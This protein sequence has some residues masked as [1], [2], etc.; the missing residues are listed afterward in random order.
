MHRATHP[1]SLCTKACCRLL[2]ITADTCFKYKIQFTVFNSLQWHPKGKEEATL[3]TVFRHAVIGSNFGRDS[4]NCLLAWKQTVFG[5]FSLFIQC[6]VLIIW[7]QSYR[8]WVAQF[9]VW[10]ETLKLQSVTFLVKNIWAVG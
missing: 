6:T 5:W 7:Q 10:E 3:H 4:R 8:I 2:F 1:A 9:G